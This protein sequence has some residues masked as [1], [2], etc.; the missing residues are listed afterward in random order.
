M[1]PNDREQK[2]PAGKQGLGHSNLQ[3]RICKRK[4]EQR[5]KRHQGPKGQQ[6]GR[7]QVILELH[8]RMKEARCRVMIQPHNTGCVCHFLSNIQRLS[9]DHTG[10]TPKPSERET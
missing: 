4:T 7:R 9:V 10:I 3:P 8:A 1:G 5:L 6:T 2:R